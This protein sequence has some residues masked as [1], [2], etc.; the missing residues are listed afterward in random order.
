MNQDDIL[1]HQLAKTLDWNEAH[2]DLD[3]AIKDF[4][5]QLRGQVPT[6]MSHSAWQLLEHIRIA[7]WDILEFSRDS[8]HKSPKWP[9]GYWPAAV[10]PPRDAA[11]KKS[12]NAIQKHLE[13]MRNLVLGRSHD[14]FKP[15]PHGK[16]QTLLRE[17]LL[18]ADHTAYHLGQMVLV[19]KSLGAWPD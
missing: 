15:L 2:V 18:A 19:R 13:E 3:T 11:W 6:G 12:V 10:A 9:E 4:P 8:K 16:G 17:V 5:A 14:L 1:R 7:L